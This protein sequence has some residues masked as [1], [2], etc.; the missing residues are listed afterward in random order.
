MSK[1]LVY[2]LENK[3]G[4]GPYQSQHKYHRHLNRQS[5]DTGHPGW[6][7]D[8]IIT[9]IW[10]TS[11]VIFRG[12]RE[13]RAGFTTLDQLQGWFAGHLNQLLK[14]GFI[15]KLYCIEGKDVIYS[16]SGKQIAFKISH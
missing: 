1:V 15:I 16:K 8:N 5:I 4:I 9:Q 10:T 3:Q 2:R 13:Y 7:D 12:E 14:A 6:M 11:K